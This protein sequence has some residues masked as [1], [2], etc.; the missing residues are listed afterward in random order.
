M[1]SGLKRCGAQVIECHSRHPIA[2]MRLISL[3]LQYLHRGRESDVVVVGA[4]CHGYVPLAWVL[5][6]L[7][8]RPLVF[9]AFV[10]TFEIWSEE[11]G[12]NR[13]SGI[14]GWR[15]FFM[16]K[17]SAVASDLVL[18]DTPEHTAYYEELLRMPE[19][20]VK[21]I[22]VGAD[23]PFFALERRPSPSFTVVFVGS[24]LPLHGVE[25]IR[26]AARLLA[27]EPEVVIELLRGPVSTPKYLEILSLADVALGAFGA[28]PKAARV[29]P[30]KVYDALAAGVPLIT[31]DTPAARRLLR[32]GEN[33]ILVPPGN[34]RA[35]ADGILQ[36]K[37]NPQLR[38]RLILEG[39]RTIEAMGTP[40]AVGRTL[41]SMCAQVNGMRA[42]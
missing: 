20:R 35:L 3:V 8:R 38:T 33:A 9:D 14:R 40:E 2:P 11:S 36:L 42:R 25:V 27:Q 37:G 12:E 22:P 24:F 6:R 17:V 31:G 7:S 5:C 41:L 34:A 16:D 18:L 23:I 13:P 21:D 10:S 30:C 39:R 29:I 15:A 32:H 26:E 4:S 1:I 19:G 28:T